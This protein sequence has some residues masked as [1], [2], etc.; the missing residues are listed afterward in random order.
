MSSQ[1]PNPEIVLLFGPDSNLLETRANLLRSIGLMADIAA[2]LSDLK[3]RVD[4]SPSNYGVVVCCHSATDAEYEEVIAIAGR[5]R[6]ALLKLEHFT[7]PLD[8][9]ERV[10]T[11]IK[12]RQSDRVDSSP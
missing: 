1:H 12:K 11:M 5:N 8:L 4:V 10:S 6:I 9:I 3:D 2:S 7:A